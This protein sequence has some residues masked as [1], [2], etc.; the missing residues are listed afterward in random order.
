METASGDRDRCN[1]GAL[2]IP[3]GADMIESC[4]WLYGR[5]VA[6]QLRPNPL[7]APQAATLSSSLAPGVIAADIDL[8]LIRN[9]WTNRDLSIILMDEILG[10]KHRNTARAPFSRGL[11]I[12]LPHAGDING[13]GRRGVDGFSTSKP[14]QVPRPRGGRSSWAC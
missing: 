13:S 8:S 9:R 12:Y 7:P 11:G 10:D 14:P 6:P 1:A 2:V 4:L 3:P 5:R